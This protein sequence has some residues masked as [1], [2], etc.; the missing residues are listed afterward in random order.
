MLVVIIHNCDR[1]L[2]VGPEPVV[3]L[4]AATA[5]ADL[6]GE[7]DQEVLVR[8]PGVVIDDLHR[9]IELGDARVEGDQLVHGHIVLTCHS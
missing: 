8:L 5:C 9:D 6:R 1:H 3:V 2:G 4:P 7:L